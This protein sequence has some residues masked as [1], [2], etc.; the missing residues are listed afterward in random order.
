[1]TLPTLIEEYPY[2][3]LINVSRFDRDQCWPKRWYLF[4]VLLRTISE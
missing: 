3:T 4:V 1:M 2:S